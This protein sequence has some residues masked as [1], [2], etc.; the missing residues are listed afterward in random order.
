MQI[1]PVSDLRN[2]FPEVEKAVETG[3]PVYLTKNGYGAMVA[4]S[5][6]QYERLTQRMDFFTEFEQLIGEAKTQVRLNPSAEQV[7]VV[8]A[9]NHI[10]YFMNNVMDGNYED[11]ERFIQQIVDENDA[12]LKYIVC[13]WNAYALDVPSFHLRKRLLEICPKNAEAI[14]ILQGEYD[15]VLKD[16]KS[17]MP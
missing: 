4:L 1:R 16:I 13:M 8:K 3:E 17:T 6:E 7:V 12:E 14:M 2:K 5:L 9:K 15:Y 10:R 11:E